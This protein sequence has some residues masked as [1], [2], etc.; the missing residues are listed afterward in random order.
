MMNMLNL[1]ITTGLADGH[2][3]ACMPAAWDFF[4]SPGSGVLQVHL[5][6]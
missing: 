4:V 5:N 6:V 2:A 3:P 1:S